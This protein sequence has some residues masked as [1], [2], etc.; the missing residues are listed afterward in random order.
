MR[1]IAYLKIHLIAFS[2]ITVLI[3]FPALN[4]GIF[5]VSLV[6]MAIAHYLYIIAVTIPFDIR[7]LKFDRGS[8]MTIPQVVGKGWAKVSS[9]VLLGT[10]MGLMLWQQPEL[11]QNPLFYIA[12][13]IQLLLAIFMNES[14]GDIY[15]AGAIDGSIA[16]LGI[17]YF[18][19]V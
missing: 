7:D 16:F 11:I 12:V 2:W 1:E 10:F 8:Q 6:W 14:K 5:S 9:V 19:I 3:L 18:F 13:I 17:S 15:C 4:E